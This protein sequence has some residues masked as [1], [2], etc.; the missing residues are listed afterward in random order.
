MYN[1]VV[2]VI[3]YLV[4]VIVYLK[5]AKRIDHICA[6][7]THIHTHTKI[8]VRGDIYVKYLYCG[9]HFTMCM[10]AKKSYCTL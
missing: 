10:Y 1:M 3:V 4:M 9:N 7:H 2:I 8:T 6:Q 5:R